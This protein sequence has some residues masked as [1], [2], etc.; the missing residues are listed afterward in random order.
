[1][2]VAE[3]YDEVLKGKYPAKAH[4]KKVVEYIVAKGGDETGIIY[5]EAQKSRLIEDNDSEA[6]FRQRRF[7]YYLSG[8]NLPDSYLT[9]N[10][11]TSTLTLFIPPIDPDEVIWSGLPMTIEEAK[12][13]YDV[14]EVKTALDVNA[15]LA[16]TEASS[17][18]TIYA[19]PEQ[20]SDSI[21][22][23][24]YESKNFDLLKT[25][26]ENC[27]VVKTEYE[28]A[29]IRKANE[30]STAA[31][32]NVMNAAANAKSEAELQGVFLKTCIERNAKNQ[33]YY[34]IV[35]AGENGATLHYIKNDAPISGQN[36]LLLDA[37]C[38][39]DC[40]ASDITRTF[41][42]TGT[43]TEES[44]GI[45]EIV[46]EMQ[47]QCIE[48]LKAGVLWD[49]IHELAH[50]IAIDGLLKLGLLKGSADDIF[51][52]RTSVAFFPHGL[53]H[54]LGMDT[55]DTGGNA[56]YA[57]KDPMFRYLRVRGT[58]PAGSVITVEPGIYFCRF[59]IE[60]YLK[61]PEQAKFIDEKVLERF[62]SVGG[63][64]IEDNILITEGGYENLTP[65][66]KELD[67]VVK[68]VKG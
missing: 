50:K 9:Y 37:G 26:I 8:C 47:T 19:I 5:L 36:L 38:E 24:S 68:L 51:K 44:K 65:T 39:V 35:A 12:A 42:I 32:V 29:L 3:N 53:G 58:L 64:R 4:A 22:F 56:N 61:D 28:I 60:P 13:K 52:A 31:H 34:S 30:I 55:H 40:Y 45:Y 57:D 43:F 1:M 2:G 18:S 7:F 23:L 17:Q 16:S 48:A 20:V 49:S 14:D 10:I 27:R 21:T 15:H 59:I 11:P 63:V 41:P 67:E 33:A 62:W 25:A 6:P 46:L 66:P 54:Y